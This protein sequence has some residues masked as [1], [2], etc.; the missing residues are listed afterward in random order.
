MPTTTVVNVRKVR[1]VRPPYDIYI[2]REARGF[3]R[4][5]WANVFK[6]GTDGKRAEV[7]EKYRTHLFDR[8][9][10]LA[11]LGSLRGKRLGCW[12]APEACHGDI[13]ANLAEQKGGE[14]TD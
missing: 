10:L 14:P 3:A 13:L 8:H 7:I 12:C 2:G 6:I 9:D 11:G 1:G 4:S 5:K